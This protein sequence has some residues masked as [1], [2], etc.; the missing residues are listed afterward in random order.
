MQQNSNFLFR[1]VLA[2][3]PINTNPSASTVLYS[4]LNQVN[5]RAYILAAKSFLRFCPDVALVVQNDGDLTAQSLRELSEH[6]PGIT[7]YDQK[8]MFTVIDQVMTDSVK[9]IMP[10]REEYFSHIPVRILYLKCFNVIARFSGKKVI[11]LDSDMLFLKQP[12]FI[13]DWIAQDYK[14]DFY[15][16]G[17]SFLA[18]RFHAMGFSFET[19][20]IANFN[21]GL[22]GIDATVPQNQ[23]KRVLSVI[24]EEDPAI[25]HEW[26]IE[27]SVWSVLLAER[28]NPVNLD[29]L[30]DVYIGSGWRTY[31]DLK[32][33]AVVAHFVGAIRYKN[34]RYLR[35]A[36]DVMSELGTTG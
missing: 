4:A 5:C 7:V 25:F 23:L 36:R 35:L 11:F 24:R 21:S 6:L 15:G 13:A 22:L 28:K 1:K 31:Q 2:T 30:C 10:P 32:T 12:A 29:D 33:N 18:E 17:G 14:G 16:G 8:S 26:E 9:A 34:F 19:L 27:Q 3:P 20:D